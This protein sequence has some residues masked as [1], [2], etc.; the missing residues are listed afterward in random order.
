M[1]FESEKDK[2]GSWIHS[3]VLKKEGSSI[4]KR[5][6]ILFLHGYLSCGATF[7]KLFNEVSKKYNIYALDLP[8]MGLSSREKFEESRSK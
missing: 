1:D 4:E 2:K 3:L 8:G 5:K 6:N 7:Y